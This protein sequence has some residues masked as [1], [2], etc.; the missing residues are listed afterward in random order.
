MRI[1]VAVFRRYQQIEKRVTTDPV[2]L[3]SN[4]ETKITFTWY[5]IQITKQ[6]VIFL[7]LNLLHIGPALSHAK[8]MS[9]SNC[10]YFSSKF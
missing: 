1:K 2:C 5:R 3:P 8:L 9:E 6:F 7:F 4:T 10:F